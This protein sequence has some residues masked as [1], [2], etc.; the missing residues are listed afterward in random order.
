MDYNKRDCIGIPSGSCSGHHLEESYLKQSSIFG[1]TLVISS[2]VWAILS[3][4][5][6]LDSAVITTVAAASNKSA[7]VVI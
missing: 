7:S 3:T 5:L 6:Q 2:L 1:T 4:V